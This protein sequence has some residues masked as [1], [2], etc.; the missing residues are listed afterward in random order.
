MAE[1]ISIVMHKRDMKRFKYDAEKESVFS[2]ISHEGKR[3]QQKKKKKKKKKEK[4][5]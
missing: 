2:D 5:M 1:K 3:S 4:R